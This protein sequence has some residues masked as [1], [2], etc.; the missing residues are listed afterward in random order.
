[1][2]KQDQSQVRNKVVIRLDKQLGFHDNESPS[3]SRQDELSEGEFTYEHFTKKR[4]STT[5]LNRQAE[6]INN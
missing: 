3:R 1:M 4:Q 6:G 5:L 2:V